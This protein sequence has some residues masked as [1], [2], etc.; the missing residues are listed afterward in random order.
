MKIKGSLRF[1]KYPRPNDTLI[2]IFFLQ[3][4]ITDN[5]HFELLK[6]PKLM[7]L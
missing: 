5:Y 2:L 7:I 4:I 3:R 1:L 6:K